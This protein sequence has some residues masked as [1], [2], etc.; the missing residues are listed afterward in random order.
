[1]LFNYIKFYIK[2]VKTTISD[3]DYGLNKSLYHVCPYAIGML[4]VPTV[5]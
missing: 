3:N 5:W 2:T 1:M 4:R